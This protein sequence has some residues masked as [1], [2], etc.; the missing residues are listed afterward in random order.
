MDQTL[1]VPTDDLRQFTKKRRKKRVD[2]FTNM[3][4]RGNKIITPL[5]E[6]KTYNVIGT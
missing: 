1:N 2:N 5:N 6:L 3:L 4:K